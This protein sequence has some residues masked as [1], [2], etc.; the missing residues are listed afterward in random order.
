MKI[1]DSSANK[2]LVMSGAFA[3]IAGVLVFVVPDQTVTAVAERIGIQEPK[4]GVKIVE[5]VDK[6]AAASPASAKS[7]FFRARRSRNAADRNATDEK[8]SSGKLKNATEKPDGA[9]PLV[10][11]REVLKATSRERGHLIEKYMYQHGGIVLLVDGRI[12]V[13]R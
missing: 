7:S 2:L 11:K 9:R 5:P 10:V 1:Q 8:S 3:V 12:M 6:E 4:V 13:E